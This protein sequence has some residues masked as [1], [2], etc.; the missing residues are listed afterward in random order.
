MYTARP[1]NS[2]FL[3]R[4]SCP[5]AARKSRV[6]ARS[7][8]RATARNVARIDRIDRID[9]ST[10]SRRNY[11]NSRSP[12]IYRTRIVPF[13]SGLHFNRAGV[14]APFRY[15]PAC[16][17][18]FIRALCGMNSRRRRR[19]GSPYRELGFSLCDHNGTPRLE[20]HD[21]TRESARERVCARARALLVYILWKPEAHTHSVWPGRAKP[22]AGVMNYTCR[23][24]DRYGISRVESR[25]V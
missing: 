16:R 1:A 5:H 3:R 2:T 10:T 12:C 21:N 23:G 13:I 19:A 9:R 22:R 8:R 11:A 18:A 15:P 17:C 6:R 7:P 20:A 24:E 14:A 4:A 25:R